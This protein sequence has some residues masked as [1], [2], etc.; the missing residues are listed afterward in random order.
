MGEEYKQ[1]PDDHLVEP[2]FGGLGLEEDKQAAP[3]KTEEQG[4]VRPKGWLLRFLEFIGW[5]SG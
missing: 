1:R 3:T 5:K 4:S 2:F